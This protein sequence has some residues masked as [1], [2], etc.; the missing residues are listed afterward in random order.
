VTTPANPDNASNKN[1]GL[2][3]FDFCYEKV[4]FIP[5]SAMAMLAGRATV[6]T[7]YVR[8]SGRLAVT[9]LNTNTMETRVVFTNRLGFYEFNDLPVGDTYVI[10]VSGKGYSFTPQTLTLLEDSAFDMFGTAMGYSTR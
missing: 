8:G 9:I 5:T 10:S 2:S 7:G 1:Y 3:H 6:N 4:S